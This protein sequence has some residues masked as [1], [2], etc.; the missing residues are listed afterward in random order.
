MS[1]AAFCPRCGLPNTQG[2]RFCP[3][4]GESLTGASRGGSEAA[5]PVKARKV[6]RADAAAAALTGPATSPPPTGETPSGY[7]P[8]PVRRANALSIVMETLRTWTK[9]LPAYLGIFALYGVG[10]IGI[11]LLTTW[12]ILGVAH[13]TTNSLVPLG[14]TAAFGLPVSY[15][16]V[17]LITPVITAL[18]SVI[19]TATVTYYALCK[20]RGAR[21]PWSV[22]FRAGVR[23]FP[24]VLVGGVLVG[25]LGT[26]V[27]A[28]DILPYV[29][30]TSGQPSPSFLA[31]ECGLLVLLVPVLFL[32]IAL[33]L[34]AP[35]VMM[36][37]VGAVASLRRSWSL[38]RGY[39]LSIFGAY[40][41]FGVLVLA[42]SFAV[43]YSLTVRGHVFVEGRVEH[44][45]LTE[46]DFR[47]DHGWPLSGVSDQDSEC[48][49]GGIVEQLVGGRGIGNVEAVGDEVLDRQIGEDVEDDA[50]AA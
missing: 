31:A 23:R 42:A 50:E 43:T 34:Y 25:L 1:L 13:P 46:G 4:C 36:E 16:C 2:H 5:Q 21:V 17:L 49:S 19:F 29:G 47:L 27:L 48:V 10:T 26:A 3:G 15:L 39:R 32:L 6:P 20:R 41:L 45:Q 24:S 18:L 33:G 22:A 28:L 8:P 11:T 35:A 44:R 9:D 37:G 7:M 14:Y 38:T 30:G 40:L 12:A